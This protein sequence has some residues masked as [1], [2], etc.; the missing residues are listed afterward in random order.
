MRCAGIQNMSV[1]SELCGTTK[2]MSEIIHRRA[3]SEDLTSSR[4]V[5]LEKLTVSQLLKKFPAI[6][7]SRKFITEFTRALHVSLS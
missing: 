4:G 2:L 1:S 5:L 3:L 6:Y 7:W